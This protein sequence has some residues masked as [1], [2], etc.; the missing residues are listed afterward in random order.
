MPPIKQLAEWQS[1]LRSFSPATILRWAKRQFGSQLTFESS[2]K[3][4]D[5]VLTSL[6]SQQNL[7][8]STFILDTGRLHEETYSLL[9]QTIARYKPP[10][11][12]YFPDWVD[13]ETMIGE[14]GPN[15][16]RQSVELRKQCCFA[17]KTKP[18]RR[19]LAGKA[20]VLTGNRSEHTSNQGKLEPID[21]DEE[22]GLY[23]INPLWNWSREKLASFIEENHV[24]VN[25]LHKEG[26][27]TISCL[28]CSRATTQDEDP[29][30]GQW[31]WE[32][33]TQKE[34]QLDL[35]PSLTPVQVSCRVE[36]IEV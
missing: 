21:W 30:V 32:H 9:E 11:Q 17:R 1:L 19:A 10:I 25:P 24:L 4:E 31:W 7:P 34:D 15:L 6:I 20:A 18:R 22:T 2:L 13:V 36:K 28:P 23:Q 35:S 3:Q 12:L 5:Q 29:Q 33:E 14:H 26:F 27:Q 8:I 16:F